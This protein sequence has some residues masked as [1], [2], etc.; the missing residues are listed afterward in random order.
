MDFCRTANSQMSKMRHLAIAGLSNRGY[1]RS[2]DG[3]D[4]DNRAC[5]RKLEALGRGFKRLFEY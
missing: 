1:G 3:E 5:L 2:K 4:W